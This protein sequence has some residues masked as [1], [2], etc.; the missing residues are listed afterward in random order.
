[1]SC[2]LDNVSVDCGVSSV[3]CSYGNFVKLQCDSQVLNT[4]TADD[5]FCD[6]FPN[7]RK[8]GMILHENRLAADDSHEISC[9]ICFFDYVAKF[10]ISSAANYRWPF[11]G[12]GSVLFNVTF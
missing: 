7:F 5:T 12:Y 1:M 8:K 3:K 10:K 4:T 6:I 2:A 11:M 9:L